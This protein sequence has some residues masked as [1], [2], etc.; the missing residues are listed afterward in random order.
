EGRNVFVAFQTL[1]I[2]SFH[3]MQANV[4]NSHTN[5]LLQLIVLDVGI[6]DARNSLNSK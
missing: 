4:D 3:D 1:I 5:T 6:C 2:S